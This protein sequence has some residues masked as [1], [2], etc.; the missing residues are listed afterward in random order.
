MRQRRWGWRFHREDQPSLCRKHR[1]LCPRRKDQRAGCVCRNTLWQKL[2][3]ALCLQ[4]LE[5]N[6]ISLFTISHQLSPF[7]LTVIPAS[8]LPAHTICSSQQPGSSMLTFLQPSDLGTGSSTCLEYPCSFYKIS[9]DFF[10]TMFNH[11]Q[12]VKLPF[13]FWVWTQHTS[14]G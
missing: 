5:G 1:L 6:R 8:L 13:L 4:M 7:D 12:S 11:T 3:E 10:K 2:A 14:F 9:S